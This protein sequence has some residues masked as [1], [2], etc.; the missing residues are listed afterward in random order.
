[1]CTQNLDAQTQSF[2]PLQCTTVVD[3]PCVSY[4]QLTCYIAQY[5]TSPQKHGTLTGTCNGALKTQIMHQQE[6]TLLHTI[7]G[8]ESEQG[9]KHEACD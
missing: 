2:A 5:Q 1:M 8:K 9:C 3:H 6:I 4:V 7:F